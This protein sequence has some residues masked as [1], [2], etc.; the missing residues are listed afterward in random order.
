MNLSYAKEYAQA[1]L[2]DM[3]ATRT[4]DVIHDL[5]IQCLRSLAFA[6]SSVAGYEMTATRVELTRRAQSIIGSMRSIYEVPESM[7]DELRRLDE[8]FHAPRSA[9]REYVLGEAI[10]AVLSLT[11]KEVSLWGWQRAV[12]NAIRQL[13]VSG[14]SGG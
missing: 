9:T 13:Y 4:N 14:G 12:T 7:I 10:N 5:R 3:E 11:D 8:A 2:T 6:V 1:W